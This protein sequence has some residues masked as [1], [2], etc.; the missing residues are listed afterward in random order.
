METH[1]SVGEFQ[2]I[3]DGLGDR[4]NPFAPE[5]G[6]RAQRRSNIKGTPIRKS[7]GNRKVAR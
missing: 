4:F 2:T 1:N 3:L 5:K 6:N 7:A